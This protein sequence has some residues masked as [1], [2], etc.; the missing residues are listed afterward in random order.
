MTS[1]SLLREAI[2]AEQ[3]AKMVILAPSFWKLFKFVEYANFDVASDSFQTFKVHF[4]PCCCYIYSCF[5]F[6]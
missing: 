1:G 2:K 6:L 5:C 4:F 3:I